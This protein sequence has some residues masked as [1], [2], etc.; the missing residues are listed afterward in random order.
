MKLKSFGCSFIY[1]S[2]LS[3]QFKTLDP[4]NDHSRLTWPA[5]IAADLGIAYECHA[6]PGVGN[7]KILCNVISE[8]SLSDPSVFVI[9]WT[10]MDRFDFVD[11]QE[12]WQTV[13]PG[14]KSQKSDLY[15]RHFHSHIKDML[16]SVMNINT[17]I[18]FLEE[19][20]IPFVMTYMD[21]DILQAVDPDWHDPRY[22]S[23]LQKK[24]RP[25]LI[26]FESKNFLDWS[27]DKG[28]DISDSWHPLEE[29]H[30]AAAELMLPAIDAILHRA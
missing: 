13:L 19:R 25:F 30:D 18:A 8:A 7:F 22:L 5:L 26:D 6:W 4:V 27:R 10:W 28:F 14:Q 16:T 9:N 2:D 1:G 17:A 20:R 21:Y 3:D 29:A 15:Y 11:D 12:Q 24:I 23:V